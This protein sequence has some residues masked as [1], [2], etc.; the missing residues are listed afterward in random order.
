MGTQE[1]VDIINTI[2]RMNIGQMEIT[3]QAL[4]LLVTGQYAEKLKPLIAK[5]ADKL[6][7]KTT[8]LFKM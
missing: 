2:F 7:E 6:P 1:A 8:F 4:F 5:Y 3:D